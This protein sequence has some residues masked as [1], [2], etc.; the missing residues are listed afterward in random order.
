MCYLKK[1]GKHWLPG[2]AQQTTPEDLH[3]REQYVPQRKLCNLVV[4]ITLLLQIVDEDG[5]IELYPIQFQI[6]KHTN[7]PPASKTSK[8][9]WASIATWLGSIG[10]GSFGVSSEA[11]P[12][13]ALGL[14]GEPI[15]PHR[16][17]YYKASFDEN[18]T[19]QQV[20]DC[21]LLLERL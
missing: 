13:P 15:I 4:N 17:L 21:L 6:Y 3:Y 7:Y 20:S 10:I 11:T 2:T 1:C 8:S 16:V 12:S 14:P 18:T 19:I 5:N 9:P